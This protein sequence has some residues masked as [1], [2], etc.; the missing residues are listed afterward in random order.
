MGEILKEK[1]WKKLYQENT[2][3]KKAGRYIEQLQE[4]RKICNHR[5]ISLLISQKRKQGWSHISK[6]T[7]NINTLYTKLN[8][9][10]QV[11]KA[12]K[13]YICPC[14]QQIKL[15]LQNH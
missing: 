1:G 6:K 9:H 15:I 7:G 13:Y 3:R 5:K 12:K 11:Y 10:T 8:S 4:E 14:I 2:N